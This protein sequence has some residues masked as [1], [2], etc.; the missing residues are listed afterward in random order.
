V[1][2]E[3]VIIHNKLGQSFPLP[4]LSEAGTPVSEPLPA[5]GNLG[6]I[7]KSRLSKFTRKLAERGRIRIRDV[8]PT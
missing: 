8:V 3:Q 5:R 2:A 4:L 6:P 7:P 1:A